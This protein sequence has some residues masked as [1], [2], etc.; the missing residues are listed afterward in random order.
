MKWETVKLA[1]CCSSIADG[2]HLPP[3]KAE[4]G[5]PF[6]TISNINSSHQF[7]FSDTMYVPQEYYDRLDS[8]R[9]AQIGDV[10]YSVVG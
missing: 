9:K 2:D 7:D 8:K 1:E 6:V 3:P 10:L 5:V 4:K